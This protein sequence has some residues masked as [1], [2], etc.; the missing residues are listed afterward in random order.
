MRRVKYNKYIRE[1]YI[2]AYSG[3][4]EALSYV[5]NPQ[6]QQRKSR[7]LW[8]DLGDLG[9]LVMLF[10]ARDNWQDHRLGIKSIYR[11][12]FLLGDGGVHAASDQG[13]VWI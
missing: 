6:V 2:K 8:L 9:G 4:R 10:G 3:A 13:A 1:A 12:H 11:Q 7:R 5:I